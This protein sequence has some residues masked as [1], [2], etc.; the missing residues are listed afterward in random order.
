MGHNTALRNWLLA[1]EL[2][3]A[4]WGFWLASR[5]GSLEGMALHSVVFHVPLWGG[6]SGIERAALMH[7]TSHQVP[8]QMT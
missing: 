6:C 8:E 4:G 2:G 7:L 5:V 1:C 3:G